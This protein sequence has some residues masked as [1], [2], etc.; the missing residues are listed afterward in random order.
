MNTLPKLTLKQQVRNPEWMPIYGDNG[1]AI[2]M[3]SFYIAVEVEAEVL[4]LNLNAGT[5][6]IRYT[7][8]ASHN[9]KGFEVLSCDTSI[10]PFL[11]LFAI[12]AKP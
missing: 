1:Q 12:V 6:R 8:P 2:N 9:K 11:E 5:M 4:T 7:R 3:D 10:K